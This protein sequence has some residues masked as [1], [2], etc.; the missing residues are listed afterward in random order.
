M[1]LAARFS[2]D[3]PTNVHEE[4]E[5]FH[6]RLDFQVSDDRPNIF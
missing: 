1:F 6:R 4:K 5:N 3:S 2:R